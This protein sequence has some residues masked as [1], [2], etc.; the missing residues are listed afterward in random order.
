MQKMATR[1]GW[2]SPDLAKDTAFVHAVI[3]TGNP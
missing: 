3:S 1:S 2:H